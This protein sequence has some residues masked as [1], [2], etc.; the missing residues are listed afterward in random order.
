MNVIENQNPGVAGLA[1]TGPSTPPHAAS[2][3]E[4]GPGS[5]TPATTDRRSTTPATEVDLILARF[6]LRARRRSLWLQHLWS[7]EGDPGGAATVTHAELNAILAD[8]DSPDAEAAWLASHADPE[9]LLEALTHVE[10]GWDAIPNSRLRRLAQIFGLTPSELDL[11]QACAAV[12]IDPALARVCAY[13]HDHAGRAGV[14]ADLAARLYDH[15]RHGAWPAESALFRWEL[16]VPC[17]TSPAEA[18]LLAC[19]PQIRDWLLG[20]TILSQP[21]VG[22]ARLHPPRPPLADWPVEATVAE[23]QPALQGSPAGRVRLH[24]AGARGSGRRTFAATVADRLGLALIVVEADQAD[25]TQWRRLFLHA[26]RQAYLDGAALAWIGESLARRPWPQVVPDFPLQFIV[27]EPGHQIPG[28]PHLIERR[29]ELP[30][31][32]ANERARLWREHLP[33]AKMWPE[34]ELDALAERHR[35]QPGD[36]ARAARLRPARAAD[37]GK[38]AR[39][40][41]RARLGPL[42]QLLETPF[43]WDD[44]VVP[45]TVQGS[46]QAIAFEAE[47]RL[48]FWEQ[49]AARR[50]FPQ[51]RGLLALFSGPPG[52]GKT[53][54]AQ[55]IA[56]H[57]G[58]DLF[59]VN[60]AQLVSK[61]VGETAKHFDFLLTQAAEMDAIVFFDEADAPFA[62]RSN[63]MRDAQDKFANTDAAF[64]LQA[65]E[66]FP[67]VAL[68]ATNL[69]GNI[70]PAF[71]RRLRHLVEFPKPDATAQQTLWT[72]LVAELAGPDRARPLEPVFTALSSGLEVTGAQIKYAILAGLFAA[73]Q[74]NRPLA[75]THLLLGLER[76]LAKEGRAIGP[77][78]RERIL[79]HV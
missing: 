54:A 64:L 34:P 67:G 32:S 20:R 50:L 2:P 14:S 36:I 6:R 11:L 58:Q 43:R 28:A 17:E 62:K 59:R 68:L 41:A 70:D 51:G 47:H 60:V 7:E 40:S 1:E 66:A 53:M 9:G 77:R 29:I 69:K 55:V 30:T 23:V 22:A 27:L 74:E 45:A 78:D 38:L 49:P 24:L 37:A 35:V 21:L 3:T 52:T 13:L 72:R 5:A 42:A 25:E 4:A 39:E 10:A 48:R 31:P 18:P 65:I 61:W 26:Q 75:A 44:L 76:E 46:L 63:E 71:F 56:A 12:A 57:L 79:K 19:D 15:G 8:R 73:Q 16:V 33:A